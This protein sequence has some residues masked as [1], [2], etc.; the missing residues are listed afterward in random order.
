MRSVIA[1]WR[2]DCV[3]WEEETSSAEVMVW[4]RYAAH[5]SDR[6]PLRDGLGTAGRQGDGDRVNVAVAVLA[7]NQV[8]DCSLG[9]VG[10]RVRVGQRIVDAGL[11]TLRG[12]QLT[13]DRRV[14]ARLL[15]VVGHCVVVGGLSFRDLSIEV[16]QAMYTCATMRRYPRVETA[17]R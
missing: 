5:V 1:P 16:L 7:A 8:A 10:L 12:T 4:L 11:L 14:F 9:V 13:Q 17:G 3:R 2:V 15:V 6:C